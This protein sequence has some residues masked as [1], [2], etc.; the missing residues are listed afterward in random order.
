MVTQT[1]HNIKIT[2]ITDF[3]G[4]FV[5]SKKTYYAFKYQISISNISANQVQLITRHW[6]IFDSLN[7]IQ[8][9]DGEGVIGI[10]PILKPLETHTYSSGCVLFSKLG[11]M[12]G[13]FNFIN[14]DST[15]VFKVFVPTFQLSDPSIFN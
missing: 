3:E 6:E 1:T 10:K 7:N 8:I 11:A 2:V 4:S 13:Y 14:H 5:K 9:V 12:K 15:A